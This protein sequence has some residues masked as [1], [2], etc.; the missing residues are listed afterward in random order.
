V[1]H[2]GRDLIDTARRRAVPYAIRKSFTFAASHILYGLPAGHP[3]GR[4]HGHNY[5]VTLELAGPDEALSPVGFLRDYRDLSAFKAC[6]DAEL[7]HRHLNDWWALNPPL[8]FPAL[9]KQR[10]ARDPDTAIMEP[11]NPTAEHLAHALYCLAEDMYPGEVAAVAVEE[12]EQ[13]WAEYRPWNARARN[14]QV[15]RRA[16]PAT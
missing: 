4:M 11:F 3:C 7:D 12:T 13:T 5:R 14:R 10:A 8:A 16:D 1:A 9:V 15:R 6:L 2:Y